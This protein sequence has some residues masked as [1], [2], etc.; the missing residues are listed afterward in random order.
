MALKN[1][2]VKLLKTISLNYKMLEN[3][4]KNGKSIMMFEFSKSALK[5]INILTQNKLKKQE[6]ET[7]FLCSHLIILKNGSCLM[8]LQGCVF[9]IQKLRLRIKQNLFGILKKYSTDLN[10]T[11]LNNYFKIFFCF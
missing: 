2:W 1:F 5:I 11:I 8:F 10:I 6:T 4:V 9:K 7:I 3:F